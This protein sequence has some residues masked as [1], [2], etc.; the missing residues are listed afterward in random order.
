MELVL[1]FIFG[2]VLAV[3]IAF[4]LFKTLSKQQEDRFTVIAQQVLD[5]NSNYITERAQADIEKVISPLNQ[6]VG[7]Y[8]SYLDNLHKYDLKDRESLRE[9]LNQMIESANRIGTEASSL[10]QALSSDVKFQGAWG[11]LTLER[12][13][14]LA[15]LEKGTEYFTQEVLQSDEGKTV[16][17]DVVIKLPNDSHIIIDS[18]VSLKAYFD[19][20][21]TDNKEAALKALKSSIQVHI[22]S[23]S[24]KQ[25]QDVA[26]VKTPDFVYLFIPVEGVYSLVLSSFPELI[27]DSIK[28]NIV[29]VSPVNIMSNLRTVASLWR[30]EKQSKNAEELARKA[31]QMYDKFVSLIDD[32]QKLGTNLK[33]AQDGHGEILKKLSEGRGNLVNRAEELKVLGA[34]TS[35]SVD[36]QLIN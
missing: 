31:G 24:K 35:K 23:L 12:I 28:K 27:D 20:I 7:E 15:G 8:K 33:R 13:L 1:A 11:E 16:R 14:E 34:K 4:F 30:L 10:T 2:V 9:R 6:R 19:Y 21:N 5:Q 29:L 36:Q 18:K 32:V 26:G 22:D 3:A 17:P 25:Y